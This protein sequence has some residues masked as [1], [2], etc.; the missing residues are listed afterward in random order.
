MKKIIFSVLLFVPFIVSARSCS[1][2]EIADLK[3]V[4]SNIT[5]KYEYVMGDD[6]TFNITLT[7][8]NDQ[9][10]IVDGGKRYDY[11]QNEL[12]I[13]GYKNGSKVKYYVYAVKCD[14]V[15]LNTIIINLPTYN[16]YYQDKVCEGA[17]NYQLCQK[18]VNVDLDYD[19]F[20]SKVNKYKAS[21]INQEK[22]PTEEIN[23][24]SILLELLL[25]YYYIPLIVII[26]YCGIKIYIINKES[27]IYS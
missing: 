22:K 4:A 25:N 26:V 18:W 5:S 27:D 19:S 1:Y 24:K 15:L 6:V 7:N 8:L 10:Y 13:S 3:K 20:V 12:T 23:E 11:T 2:T 16:K 14:K 17:S 9:I 21:L